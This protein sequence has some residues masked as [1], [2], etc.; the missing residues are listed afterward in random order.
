MLE[1]KILGMVIVIEKDTDDHLLYF[2]MALSPYIWGFWNTIWP[3]IVIDGTLLKGT[4]RGKLFIASVLDEN[5]K[6]YLVA[7][8]VVDLENDASWGGFC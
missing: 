2:F 8:G 4:Y 3:V 5:D 6:I 1:E 7:F